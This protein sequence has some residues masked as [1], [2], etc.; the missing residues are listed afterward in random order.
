[1]HADTASR[2]PFARIRL[3][4]LLAPLAV[5][6][7]LVVGGYTMLSS[8]AEE[9]AST[10][11]PIQSESTTPAVDPVTTTAGAVTTIAAN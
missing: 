8:F 5:S 11:K 10:V 6:V 1:M 7:G 9:V 2:A 4:Y 3:V